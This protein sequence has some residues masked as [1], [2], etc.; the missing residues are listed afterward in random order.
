MNTNDHKA[1]STQFYFS[2][3][4][5]QSYN[6]SRCGWLSTLAIVSVLIYFFIS[7]YL[8]VSISGNVHLVE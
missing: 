2:N 4:E 6:S 3:V 7:F 5:K 1:I 8:L